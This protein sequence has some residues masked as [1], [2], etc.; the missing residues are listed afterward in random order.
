M[1]IRTGIPGVRATKTV[2]YFIAQVVRCK[3]LIKSPESKGLV[4]STFGTFI[5]CAL[6][7]RLIDGKQPW[8]RHYSDG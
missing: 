3:F 4:R 2:F 8:A 1:Q 7:C 6:L 5:A